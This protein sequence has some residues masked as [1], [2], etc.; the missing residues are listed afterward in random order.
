M[1]SDGRP[2]RFGGIDIDDEIEVLLRNRSG[3]CHAFE[4]D[5]VAPYLLTEHA[6]Y[7]FLGAQGCGQ[8]Q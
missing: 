6:E 1:I 8:V 3:F 2:G 7:G 5:D 4:V